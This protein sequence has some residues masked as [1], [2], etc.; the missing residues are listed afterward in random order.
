MVGTR[1]DERSPHEADVGAHE[2]RIGPREL[3]SCHQLA[4]AP[5]LAMVL[6][7]SRR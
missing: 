5:E 3:P 7:G 1:V 2:E 4:S 6:A